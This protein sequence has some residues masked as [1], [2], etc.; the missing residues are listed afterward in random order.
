MTEVESSAW[1]SFVLVVKNFLGNHRA[2]NYVELVNRMLESFKQLGANM[3]IKVHFLFSHLGRFPQNLG[4]VSDEQGERFHQDMRDMEERY[5][6]YWDINMMADYCWSIAR[7]CPET[8]HKR[9]A[10]KR[11]FGP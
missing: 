5:Q 6:G 11:S 7:D 8:K 3:S 2:E 1:S 4:S 9:Q 10:K